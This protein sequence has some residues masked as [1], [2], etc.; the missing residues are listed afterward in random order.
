MESEATKKMSFVELNGSLQVKNVLRVLAK[1]DIILATWNNQLA[2]CPSEALCIVPILHVP[3]TDIPKRRH[4]CG[5]CQM[6]KYK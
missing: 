5:Q 4:F 3:N 6:E 2:L 1:C